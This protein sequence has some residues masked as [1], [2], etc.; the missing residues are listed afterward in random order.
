[1]TARERPHS[2]FE[3]VALTADGVRLIDQRRLPSEEVYLLARTVDEVADAIVQMAIRGAPAIGIAGAMGVVLAARGGARGPDLEA[4]LE[5]LASTRPTAVNLFWALERMRRVATAAE[6]EAPETLE[7]R[8]TDEAH[9]IWAE[10][11]EMCRGIGAHGAAL[12]PLGSRVLTHCNAGG[13]ATAGWG[14]A[15]GVIRSAHAQGRIAHVYADETRPFLQGSRL[16]AWELQKDGIPVS[17]LCDNM[18]AHYMK[19]GLIDAVIV[20]TDRVAANGDI[21]N[22]IGTYAVALCARAHGLPFYVAGPSSTIDLSCPN[23]DAIPIEQR[24]ARE[25]THLGST[26]LVPEGVAVENPAFDVTPADLVTALITERGVL[27][28][29]YGQALAETFGRARSP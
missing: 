12:L 21:A 28:A 7:A 5:R 4:A 3:T 20:G 29:P 16:T 1:V 11:L 15:L 19:R 14:T 2:A 6:A 8:L 23:G 22:K 24:P 26:R 10:D 25:V 13:L 27:R 9:A 18:A 17:V